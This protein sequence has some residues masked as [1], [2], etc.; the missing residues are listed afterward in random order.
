MAGRFI[1]FEGGEGAGKTTQVDLLSTYLENKGIR[2]VRTREPGGT[3]VA[4]DI[5]NI[6]V[7]GAGDKLDPLTEVLLI[8][9]ARNEHVRKV[10]RP[11]LA[12]GDWVIC[13]RFYD[14][15]VAYQGYGQKYNLEIIETIKHMVVADFQPDMTFYLQLPVE[16]GLRR[17]AA[18]DGTQQGRF[19]SLELHFH[20]AMIEGFDNIAAN[21]PQ[22][23]RTVDARQDIAEIQREIRNL[24]QGLISKI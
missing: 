22:R 10:I 9:A 11:A 4:E 21:N 2:V 20:Q 15:T 3:P 12:R 24:I 23:V 17:A 19:E 7:H 13:D 18:R 6:L 8:F 16:E 5:R 14:S 1:T